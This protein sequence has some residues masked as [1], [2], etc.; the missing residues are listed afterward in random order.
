MALGLICRNGRCRLSRVINFIVMP[1]TDCRERRKDYITDNNRDNESFFYI[2]H[3]VKSFFREES[4][5]EELYRHIQ[6]YNI[7][8]QIM[9]SFL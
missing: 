3:I 6:A 4:I 5:V 7:D 9:I 2:R 8:D 1:P